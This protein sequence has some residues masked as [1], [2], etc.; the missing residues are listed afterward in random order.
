M[1]LKLVD[2][3]DVAGK[4]VLLR[5]DL[6]MPVS[7]D[8]QVVS[9]IR[10]DNL[11]YTL[12]KLQKKGAITV[13]IGHR[14]RPKGRLN[15]SLSLAPIAKHLSNLYGEEVRFVPECTGRPAEAAVANAKPG[16]IIMLENLRFHRE[17]E[18]NDQEFAKALASLGQAYV[19]DAFATCHRM[20]A[21][22]DALPRLMPLKGIGRH[23]AKELEA[24]RNLTGTSYNPLTIVMGGDK[25]YGKLQALRIMLPKVR[26]AMLSGKLATTFW[27]ARGTR[28]GESSYAPEAMDLARQI[29]T[30]AGVSGCRIMLPSD[31]VTSPLQSGGSRQV[32]PLAEITAGEHVVDIG[33]QT[34][35]TWSHIIIPQ[36][37]NIVLNGSMGFGAKSTIEI[38]H[39]IAKQK[40]AY[41]M[42]FGADTLAAIEQNGLTLDAFNY[43]SSASGS[44]LKMMAGEA[45]PAFSALDDEY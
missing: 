2:S 30:E 42:V 7:T 4:V 19:N 24:T 40:E 23:L 10:L 39:A 41:T 36:A 35:E 11:L 16:D 3:M 32:K 45:L 31:V 21:S 22:L 34:I 15:P 44:V 1:T 26:H 5:A 25:V 38:A 12:T 14:G 18:T 33:P 28:I 29:L 8:N 6:D 37:Q 27:A 9:D 13:I 43:T 17:E 20:H